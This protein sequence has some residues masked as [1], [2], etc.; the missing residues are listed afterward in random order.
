GFGK[1]T[2]SEKQNDI[3]VT[4]IVVE[5]NQVRVKGE[6]TVRASVDAPGF[7][8]ARVKVSLLL[9][10]QVLASNIETLRLTTGNSVQLKCTAPPQPSEVKVTLKIEPQPNETITT[11]NEMTT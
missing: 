10:D 5:P 1:T 8:N 4:S 2:T 6:M 3:T 9:D 11:N 7:E